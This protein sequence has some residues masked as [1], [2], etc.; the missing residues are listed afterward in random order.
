LLTD[1]VPCLLGAVGEEGNQVSPYST[2]LKLFKL[3]S[4]AV[5]QRGMGLKKVNWED[6]ECTMGTG[7]WALC[8]NL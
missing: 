6:G 2:K 3:V 4:V 8:V 5:D 7:H 1:R